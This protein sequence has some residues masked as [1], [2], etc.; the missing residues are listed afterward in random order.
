MLLVLRPEKYPRKHLM[1]L[2][3]DCQYIKG[4]Q[5]KAIE[6]HIVATYMIFQRKPC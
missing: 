4:K 2:K 3:I 6:I 5:N 1:Q